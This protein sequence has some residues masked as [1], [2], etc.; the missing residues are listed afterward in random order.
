MKWQEVIENPYLQNIPFKVETNEFGQIVMNPV[1]IKHS[2]FQGKLSTLMQNMRNDGVILTECAVWTRRGTKC[3]DVAWASMELF[4]QIENQT[5]ALIAPEVCVEVISMSNSEKE[6]KQKRKLYFEQGAI[7][8][9]MCSDYGEM[10]FYM[11][12]SKI[13]QSIMFP[14]FPKN[15]G[16]KR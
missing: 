8:V 4:E 3:A 13:E 14:D 11:Q 7:E 10:S 2:Y 5:N 9:W 16:M 6:M 15:I 12:D 1:K